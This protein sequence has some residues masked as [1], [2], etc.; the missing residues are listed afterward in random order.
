MFLIGGPFQA[1]CPPPQLQVLWG[2]KHGTGAKGCKWTR[3]WLKAVGSNI[4]N[5]TSGWPH[6]LESSWKSLN[7]FSPFF[8][9]LE[10]P[11]KW[12]RTLKVL[13]FDVRG[14]WISILQNRRYH[15]LK[16]L[17]SLHSSP[18]Q[19]T[20]ASFY[21]LN[22][23]ITKQ[24]KWL[25]ETFRKSFVLFVRMF[26]AYWLI[27]RFSCFWAWLCLQGF[28]TALNTREFNIFLYTHQ[29]EWRW[30]CVCIS[31]LDTRLPPVIVSGPQNQTLPLGGDASLL[32]VV[33]GQPTPHVYWFKN[34]RVLASVG[35]DPRFVIVDFGT[36][37][38]SSNTDF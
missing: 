38:I 25:P 24:N 15:A 16:V 22:W 17:Q 18:M 4:N 14:P 23:W 12:N 6:G 27:S 28:A 19:Y 21:I 13:E 33:D 30:Q 37:Q 10:S 36:L 7:F 8:Q 11:W 32:C 31:E 9:D 20:T 34:E 26:I 2:F 5:V 3:G 1:L 35:R 29:H